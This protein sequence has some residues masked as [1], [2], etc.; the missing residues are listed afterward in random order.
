MHIRSADNQPAYIVRNAHHPVAASLAMVSFSALRSCFLMCVC[1]CVCRLVSC[2]MLICMQSSSCSW[3]WMVCSALLRPQDP[4]P[5]MTAINLQGMWTLL[6]SMPL[7]HMPLSSSSLL[8]QV[9]ARFP[10]R[11]GLPATHQLTKVGYFHLPYHPART[12]LQTP[13]GCIHP[14]HWLG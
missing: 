14:Q 11:C 4:N 1:V 10:A 12:P 3:H 6:S 5:I 7:S 2:Q 9:R 8:V 13:L